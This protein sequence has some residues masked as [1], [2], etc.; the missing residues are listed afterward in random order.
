[1]RGTNVA[2]E[3]HEI[4]EVFNGT[5]EKMKGLIGLIKEQT[6]GLSNTGRELSTNMTETSSSITEMTAHITVMKD[7]IQRQTLES[8]ESNAVMERI[9]EK[10]AVLNQHIVQQTDTVAQSASS[11]EEMIANI[12]S[13]SDTLNKNSD[14]VRALIES[15]E[16]GKASLEKVST[17]FQEIARESEGLLEI[18]G[19][20]NMIA[21][22]T[23]LLSMNAAIEAAHAGEVGKGF[24][25]VA[26]EIRKLA[27]SSAKQSKTT[28]TMLKKIKASIDSL[29]QSIAEVLN[30]FESID[31]EVTTV[32][33]QETGIRSAMEEQAEGSKHILEAVEELH[34]IT[35][36]VK[37][38]SEEISAE[39]REVRNKNAALGRISE[40]VAKGIDEM[41]AGAEQINRAVVRVNEISC[42]NK[43]SIGV[44]QEEMS[45]F[46][47]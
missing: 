20:M 36:L 27:E 5:F 1:M 29:T 12:H 28:G 41:A 40:E 44:L 43:D 34:T 33:R 37:R 7:K 42:T 39:S 26:E 38:K 45:T 22:Q 3:I 24:A 13:V 8:G 19:V 14:N 11:I 35:D 25:V 23:N 21:S 15:S 46:K 4:A 17:G 30:R 2:V 31:Q 9:I 6:Q 47:V 18:N 32:S 16:I 10:I